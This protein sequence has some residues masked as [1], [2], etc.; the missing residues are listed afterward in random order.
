MK[1]KNDTGFFWASY[2]DLMTSLFFIMLVLYVLTFIKLKFQQKATED[3]LQK[4]KEIQAAVKEL[5]Q[6]YFEYDLANKRFLLKK[7]IQFDTKESA[8][9]PEYNQY[10]FEVGVSV[11]ELINKL[12]ANYTNEDIKYLIVIEGMSSKDNYIEN[13]ELSYKRALSLYRFWES[14]G[15]HF[16]PNVC[17][18]QIAGSGIGGVGRFVNNEEYKNQRFLIQVVPKIGEIKLDQ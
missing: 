18:V 6:D 7:Q 13:Y 16:D 10:L 1:K 2:T 4:I 5:P 14:K 11:V 15:L 8:I 12:K 9:R 3:Q 17:E